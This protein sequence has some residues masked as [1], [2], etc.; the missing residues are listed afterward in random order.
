M[1]HHLNE[2]NVFTFQV[3]LCASSCAFV[4][5]ITYFYYDTPNSIINQSQGKNSSFRF[6]AQFTEIISFYLEYA[7]K[8][9]QEKIYESLLNYI[10]FYVYFLTGKIRASDV[11]TSQEKR[12]FSKKI[13]TFP[14][15][16]KEILKLKRKKIFFLTNWIIFQMPF[17][18][19]IFEF[20]L[21][22]S[23][24]KKKIFD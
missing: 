14:L 1:P 2:D 5:D 18:Y 22:L 16:L 3:L 9:R 7:Q 12:I 11:I 21:G 20:I 4:P 8:Y 10:I 17:R 13:A 19:R 24:V 23:R 15:P 6:C